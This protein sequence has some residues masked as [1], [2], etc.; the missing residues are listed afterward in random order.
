[1]P[2]ANPPAKIM[3]MAVSSRKLARRLIRV[4]TREAGT[5]QTSAPQNTLPPK[6]KA[7]D[8][9]AR[10]EWATAS[11]M[12]AIPFKTTKAPTRAQTTAANP[13]ASKARCIKRNSRGPI[14]KSIIQVH[15]RFLAGH[16]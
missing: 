6:M 12:K 3:P 15:L 14:I 2:R 11:P 13:A 4:M 7:T 1:M 5:A 9:P 8:M 10:E 16:N